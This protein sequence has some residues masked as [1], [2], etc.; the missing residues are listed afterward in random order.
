LGGPAALL[1]RYQE[2]HRQADDGLWPDG[3]HRRPLCG[4]RRGRRRGHRRS[5]ECPAARGYFGPT[6]CNLREGR[7]L[8]DRLRLHRRVRRPTWRE[9]IID[10]SLAAKNLREEL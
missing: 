2:I 9:P 8:A 7:L 4:K 1:Y 5:R 3:H 6:L 10:S